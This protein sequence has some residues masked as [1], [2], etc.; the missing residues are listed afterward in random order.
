MPIDEPGGELVFFPGGNALSTDSG[1]REGDLKELKLV[2]KEPEGPTFD[3]EATREKMIEDYKAL[4][5]RVEA[6]MGM[7]SLRLD[8]LIEAQMNA[9]NLSSWLYEKRVLGEDLLMWLDELDMSEL[10]FDR[11]MMLRMV[12]C[13]DIGSTPDHANFLEQAELYY[14]IAIQVLDLGESHFEPRINLVQWDEGVAD[15]DLIAVRVQIAALWKQ[16]R[17]SDVHDRPRLTE[18]LEDNEAE[19]PAEVL[20]ASANSR[21]GPILVFSRDE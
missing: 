10:G 17:E 16:F 9:L 18:L 3:P 2:P 11:E 14:A 12:L 13:I 21:P 8:E 19:E 15:A 1:P 6:V 4:A 5:I 7:M 20:F